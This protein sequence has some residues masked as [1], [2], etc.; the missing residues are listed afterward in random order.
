MKKALLKYCLENQCCK[1]RSTAIGRIRNKSSANREK[2]NPMT[3]K[4]NIKQKSVKK[5]KYYQIFQYFF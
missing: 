1:K 3:F 5:L 2:H 4:M